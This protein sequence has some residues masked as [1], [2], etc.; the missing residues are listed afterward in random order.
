MNL[1]S[2]DLDKTV[3]NRKMLYQIADVIETYP[4]RHNQEA[5]IENEYGEA[6]SSVIYN[7]EE[8]SCGTTQCV[9]GWALILNNKG[10]QAVDYSSSLSDEYIFADSNSSNSH[11]IMLDAASILG[12]SE[13]DAHT[14]FYTT[15]IEDYDSF[16]MPRVLREIAD[17]RSVANAIDDAHSR[18][19]NRYR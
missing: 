14:L 8:I 12:L 4:E 3:P 9:A 17:G 16:D 7:G 15:D 5:W 11:S 2:D 18:H 1:Y 6:E 10:L 19:E 13:K